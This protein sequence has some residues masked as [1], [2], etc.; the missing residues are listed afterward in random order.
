MGYFNNTR[1]EW[2]AR[3]HMKVAFPKFSD[4]DH[5]KLVNQEGRLTIRFNKKS[6]VTFEPDGSVTVKRI[7]NKKEYK[8]TWPMNMEELDRQAR[9]WKLDRTSVSR[10]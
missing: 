6:E 10:M 9:K 2:L 4:F 8:L 1:L 3:R 7:I 5:P